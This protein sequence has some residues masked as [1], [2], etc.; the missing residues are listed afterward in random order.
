MFLEISQNS[1]ENTCARASFYYSCRLLK[2]GS[3]AGVFSCEFCEIFKDTFLTEHFQKN[4]SV[5][6]Y[7]GHPFIFHSLFPLALEDCAIKLWLRKV[8]F[9]KKL[10]L[11]SY[12]LSI[13]KDKTPGDGGHFWAGS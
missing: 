9:L 5:N 4:A 3:G 2:R 8:L 6:S 13:P 10:E 1:Q 12:V 7:R 11:I